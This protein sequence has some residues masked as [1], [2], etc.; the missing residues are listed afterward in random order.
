M[1]RRAKGLE[2][3][4]CMTWNTCLSQRNTGANQITLEPRIRVWAGAEGSRVPRSKSRIGAELTSVQV[5]QPCKK[6]SHYSSAPSPSPRANRGRQ[7]SAP[8]HRHARQSGCTNEDVAERDEQADQQSQRK[9]NEAAEVT[10]SSMLLIAV[11]EERVE[12]RT[13]DMFSLGSLQ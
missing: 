3:F 2:A 13:C 12:T 5:A 4:P 1:L 6:V 10:L 11:F 8:L 9:V 7:R